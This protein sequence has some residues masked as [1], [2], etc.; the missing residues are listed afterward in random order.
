MKAK[1]KLTTVL[2]NGWPGTVPINAHPSWH[3][4][5]YV[6]LSGWQGTP[7]TGWQKPFRS[8]MARG[9]YILLSALLA[10]MILGLVLSLA[11]SA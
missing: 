3:S 1:S 9:A 11:G 7:G 2:W 5:A 10:I 4:A 8:R 6:R